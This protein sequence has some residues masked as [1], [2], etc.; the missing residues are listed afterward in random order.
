MLLWTCY[1]CRCTDFEQNGHS[2]LNA[3]EAH[4]PSHYSPLIRNYQFPPDKNSNF[5]LLKRIF[6]FHYSHFFY[7]YIRIFRSISIWNNFINNNVH[8][9]AWMTIGNM[10]R[11]YNRYSV[12]IF[13]DN[14]TSYGIIYIYRYIPVGWTSMIY[15]LC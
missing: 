14:V 6:N 15:N 4:H 3:L 7:L 13:N 12:S 11:V 1:K 9:H 8:V 10:R 2:N 5:Y